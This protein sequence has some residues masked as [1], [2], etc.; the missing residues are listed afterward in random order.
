MAERAPT[1]PRPSASIG[2]K[3]TAA[4]LAER[5]ESIAS[6]TERFR[7]ELLALLEGL[8][9]KGL[10]RE[11]AIAALFPS[12]ILPYDTYE[13][14]VA[15]LVSGAHLLFFGPSG[16]GKTSLAKA[17][18]DLFPKAT[19][20]VPGC[21]VLDHPLSLV[22]AE[23]AARFPP[24][25]ICRRRFVPEGDVARW[26]PGSVDPK[27]V[28]A[29]VVRLRE[30]YGFARLQGSSE[31]FPDHLTGNVNLRRLEEI[32]D[33]MSPLVLEPGK[34]LQANRGL[35]L[36]D[37]IGKLPLGTQNVLLQ[38]LQEGT[39]TPSKSRESFPA[40]FVAICTSNLSDLD[41]INDPLSDRLTS[42]HVGFNSRH[43]ENR[44][45]VDLGYTASGGAYLPEILLDAGVRTIELWRLRAT[46]DNPDTGEV[47]SNRTLIDVA[48]RTSAFAVLAGRP[49]PTAEDLKSGLLHAMRGRIRARSGESFQQN[50]RR[51][52]EFLNNHLEEA[53]KRSSLVYWCR[54]F[55]GPL[56]ENAGEAE[57]LVG[58]G[59]RLLPDASLQAQLSDGGSL[60]PRFQTF[61]GWVRDRERPP[62]PVTP[63]DAALAEFSLLERHSLFRCEPGAEDDVGA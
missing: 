36:V 63:R 13:D 62:S 24:C 8:R 45:I 60:F 44:R 5:G 27:A 9:A 28:P 40:S 20:V 19:W 7:T 51:V 53:L 55:R 39:V 43:A 21:P 57:A 31:V 23:L 2:A 37:E 33:P 49:V 46:D 15:A 10:T 38:A 12:T 22:D 30:G 61:L 11:Q 18:W 52:Q 32:G 25:P 29:E 50:T 17:L 16:A 3:A 47:G 59:R 14:L 41:N 4:Q 42:L 26:N 34:L 48:H 1:A 58:E 56:R 6:P 54:Y 35:L